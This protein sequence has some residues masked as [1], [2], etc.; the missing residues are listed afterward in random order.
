MDGAGRS[1]AGLKIRSAA[2]MTSRLPSVF[3]VPA[4]DSGAV[5]YPNPSPVQEVG[6]S[7]LSTSDVCGG[8]QQLTGGEGAGGAEEGPKPPQKGVHG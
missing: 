2:T 3:R 8:Q 5:E 4:Y 1:P 7:G 6:L